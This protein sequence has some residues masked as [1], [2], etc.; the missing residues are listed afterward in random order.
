MLADKIIGKRPEIVSVLALQHEQDT[1]ATVHS[2]ACH[3][4]DRRPQSAG[5]GRILPPDS[6]GDPDEQVEDEDKGKKGDEHQRDQERKES[7]AEV[8]CVQRRDQ[9]QPERCEAVEPDPLSRNW[10]Q[11]CTVLL[12]HESAAP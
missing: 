1:G 8:A 5:Q 7:R 3:G 9:Q 4:G 12:S 2:H 10:R 11:S 6:V